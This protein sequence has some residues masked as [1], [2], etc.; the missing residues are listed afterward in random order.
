MPP[1]MSP[2]REAFTHRS[3][4][5][6][7]VGLLRN[8]MYSKHGAA[9]E[10]VQ[11]KVINVL[12]KQLFSTL[13]W[14]QKH[15]RLIMFQTAVPKVINSPARA[16]HDQKLLHRDAGVCGTKGRCVFCKRL[17]TKRRNLQACLQIKPK[18]HINNQKWLY[19]CL[20]AWFENGLGSA[21]SFFPLPSSLWMCVIPLPMASHLADTYY[22]A[23]WNSKYSC[24]YKWR[25]QWT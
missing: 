18:K 17:N 25:G 14:K 16:G 21:I 10:I 19:V 13:I 23:S 20:F 3:L 4:F 11:V 1:R 8:Y 6:K 2:A 24:G 15:L 22:A 9:G 5:C 12:T 7:A